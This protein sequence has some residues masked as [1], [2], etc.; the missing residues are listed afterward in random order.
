MASTR[1][2]AGG[3]LKFDLDLDD[4]IQRTFYFTRWYE[5]RF[6]EFLGDELH[7]DDVYIDVGAHVG[8]DA[9]F[10]ARRCAQVVAFE[11]AP[12]TAAVLS[13]TAGQVDNIVVVPLALA[14]EVGYLELKAN[15]AWQDQRPARCTGRDQLWRRL[16]SYRSTFGLRRGRISGWT[17]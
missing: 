15:P 9:V 7:A 8:I 5:R 6:L 17:S 12:D 10:A 2:C 4:H 11:A 16:K 13:R 3:A 1:E 14:A